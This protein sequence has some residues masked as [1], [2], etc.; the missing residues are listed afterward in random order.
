MNVAMSM[1]RWTSRARRHW[2]GYLGGSIL[3]MFLVAAIFAPQ[4]AAHEPNNVD[5]DASLRTPGVLNLL[6]TD[7]L[8]RDVFSRLVHGARSTMGIAIPVAIS[9]TLLGI[10]VGLA[11]G[12]FG[13]WTDTGI[14]TLLNALFAL[15]GLVLS[16][17]VLALLG[18]GHFGLL[19]ALTASG[20]ASF[21]RIVRGPTLS[22]RETEYVVAARAVGASDIH[23]LRRHVCPN[24]LGPVLVLATL[25]LGTV[26]LAISALSFLGL[27]NQPPTA[28]WGAMLNDGRP[29]FRSHSHLMLVPG[30]AIF[31]LVLGANLL[32]DTLRDA[33]DPRHP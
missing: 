32:G 22:V 23:I 6:G 9:V 11:A 25:D 26:V 29:Y 18:S 3:A 17:A 15:P 20:W 31:L 2:T 14:S 5:L 24:I 16:L 1:R 8:G 21:A 7:Q 30:V 13:G 27:G 19:V 28:E 10:A 33:F 4:L 12:Y